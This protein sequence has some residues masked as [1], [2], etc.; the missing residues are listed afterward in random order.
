MD[1]VIISAASVEE[2]IEKLKMVLNFSREYRLEINVKKSQFLKKCIEFLGHVI[3]EGM[4]YPSVLKTQAVLNFPK[5][6]NN[7][8][9]QSYLC[10]TGFFVN[11]CLN[12]QSLRDH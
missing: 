7:K 10:L 9:I 8:Q 1:D 5:P 11:S 4:I 2:A 6:K 12:I 3:E